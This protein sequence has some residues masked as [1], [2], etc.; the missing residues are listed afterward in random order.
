MELAVERLVALCCFVIGLSHIVQPRAWA[1][2]FIN[3]REKGVLGVFYTGLLHFA[4]GAIIVA[5]H[6]VWR[7]IPM[8]VTLLGWGWTIKGLLHLTYPSHG[9]RMLNRVSVER[10]WEFSVAGVVLLLV[11]AVITW[12]LHHRGGF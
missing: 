8:I 1:G 9:L 3:W 12:S 11:A 6:N 10:S 4:L 7:G 5:F 2:L